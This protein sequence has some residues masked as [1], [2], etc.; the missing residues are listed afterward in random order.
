M[1]YDIT[2]FNGHELLIDKIL[3][4]MINVQLVG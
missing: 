2:N 1:L 3:M 4:A